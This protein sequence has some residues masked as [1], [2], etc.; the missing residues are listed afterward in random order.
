MTVQVVPISA[1]VAA[2]RAWEAYR[3]VL[4]RHRA[5][6]ALWDDPDR[7]RERADAHR[8]FQEIFEKAA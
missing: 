7:I 2:A 4:L 1:E 3:A 8:E 6:P 5:E